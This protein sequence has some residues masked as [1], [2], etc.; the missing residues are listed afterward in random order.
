MVAFLVVVHCSVLLFILFILS[1]RLP[2]SL[3]CFI[4][5][6]VACLCDLCS[7]FSL[8]LFCWV[9]MIV[10]FGACICVCLS[11]NVEC[12]LAIGVSINFPVVELH[13]ILNVSTLVK[14]RGMEKQSAYRSYFIYLF[15]VFFLLF[16]HNF[17]VSILFLLF[18]SFAFNSLDANIFCLLVLLSL[19]YTVCMTTACSFFLFQP[20]FHFFRLTVL[21]LY[22]FNFFHCPY[23][24]VP[25]LV[26]LLF[27]VCCSPSTFL[28]SFLQLVSIVHFL[29]FNFS[30]SMHGISF[31]IA[32]A[33]VL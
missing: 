2:C 28:S 30:L 3:L 19:S 21:Q 23:Y 31:V 12:A 5:A 1:L 8:S 18:P 24:D 33:C 13:C 26:L 29:S 25:F 14:I 27:P 11:I 15:F 10:L 9:V 20:S 32:D 22:F 16:R 4:F 7:S 6:C 17:F